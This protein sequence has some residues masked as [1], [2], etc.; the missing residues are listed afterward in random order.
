MNGHP[1]ISWDEALAVANEAFVRAERAYNPN[2]G[3][4]STHL[5]NWVYYSLLNYLNAYPF[6]PPISDSEVLIDYNNNG[7]RNL[8]FKQW[9]E[10][11][12]EDAQE[13]IN[14]IM[15][16][17]KELVNEIASTSRGLNSACICRYLMKKDWTE[18][19][20]NTSFKEIRKGLRQL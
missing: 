13:I 14:L 12:R 2:K 19:R 16:S 3:S 1:Y 4:F 10:G 5:W 15:E 9:L 18:Y 20:I 6:P 8:R 11:L 17:P 7:E